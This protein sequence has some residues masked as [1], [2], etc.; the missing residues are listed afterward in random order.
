M[1]L[2]EV[3]SFRPR[4]TLDL[5]GRRLTDIEVAS[6]YYIA[7]ELIGAREGTFSNIKA[8]KEMLYG[9]NLGPYYVAWQQ[10]LNASLVPKLAPGEGVYIEASIEAKMRGSFEEQIDY[11][12]TAVG[13][14]FMTRNEA[15]PRLNLPKVEGGDELI[16][17]LNVLLG[18]QASPQD[19]K[20]L[21]GV[22]L[23][24]QQRQ[25]H[26]VLSQKR[27]GAFDWWDRDRWDRELAEDL[28]KAGLEAGAAEALARRINDQTEREF[29]DERSRDAHE[30]D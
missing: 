22:V 3:S 26:I 15:R 19:G 16:T 17:P 11:L 7:P 29:L 20:S 30:D 27:A 2:K 1:T 14:P 10:A 6:A 4:D 18:G 9:P 23:K 25:R 13:A 8:F 5:D 24:F 28:T 21:D 12:S